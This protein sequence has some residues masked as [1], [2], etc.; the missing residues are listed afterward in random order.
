MKKRVLSALL[1]G[2]MSFSLLAGGSVA[3]AA[4][5]VYDM[6]MEIITYGF[7]DV[8]LQEVEDAVNEISVPEV[9]VRVHFVTVPISE[10]MTKL[11]LMAASNEKIDLVQSGLLTTPAMLANQGLIQPMTD[12]LSDAMKE[13]AGALIHAGTIGDDI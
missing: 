5:D 11:P 6:N 12:Y 3:S 1:T 9:G 4:E 10:M 7:D 13:K 8:D 2:I